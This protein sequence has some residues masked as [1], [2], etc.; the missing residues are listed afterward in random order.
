MGSVRGQALAATYVW[1]LTVAD[2]PTFW[3]YIPDLPPSTSSGEFV[4]QDE[5][6]SDIY[7]T[8][9]TLPGKSGIVS[10]RLPSTTA[11]LETSKMYHWYFKVDCNQQGASGLIFV[12][13]WVQRITPNPSLESQLTAAT[14]QQQ[15]A[16]YAANGIWHETLTSLA[17]LRQLNLEDAA[18]TT[19]WA[20]L[21][22]SVGLSEIASAPLVQCC[23][24]KNLDAV[25]ASQVE[26]N[27]QEMTQ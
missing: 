3:F 23:T 8:P 18:L 27:F 20:E 17:K 4:L 2:Y 26:K 14:P 9:I 16:L 7:R 19:D 24:P 6:G 11:P 5:M 1:G 12:E 22:Q 13:G 10:F 25:S 15:V 21:L